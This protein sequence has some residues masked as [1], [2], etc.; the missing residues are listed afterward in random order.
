MY[1]TMYGLCLSLVVAGVLWPYVGHA[2]GP[3]APAEVFHV[4]PDG[5]DGWSGR[6]AE[7]HPDGADGPWASIAGARDGLRRLRQEG[8]LEGPVLVYVR[9]GEYALTEPVVFGPEDSGTA[10]AHV[11][12]AAYPGETPLLHGGVSITGWEQDGA[13]W[14]ARVPDADAS[15]RPTALWVDGQRRTPARTPNAANEAGDYPTDADFFF[16]AGQLSETDAEGNEVKSRTKFQFRPGDLQAWDSLD[17]AWVVVYHSWATSLLPVKALDLE[18]HVAEFTGPARWPFGQWRSDQW[19]YVEHLREGLDQPGE[20]FYDRDARTMH[21]MPMP[22]EDMAA[23]EAIAPVAE[24]LLLLEG[25]PENGE[26][27]EFLNFRGL[28]F[29]YTNYVLAET[30]ISD[31]QAAFTV[32]AAVQAIGARNCAI[33]HCEIRHV[34]NYAVWWRRG[35]QDNRLFHCEL[36]DMGAGGVRIG[37]GSDPATP[38]EAALR[39]VID[40]N[41]IH[42]GG[43]LFREAVGV[44]IGRSSWNTVSHNEICDFRYSGV[45]VGW[46]W[47]YAESSANHN[48]IEFNHIHA[49]GK[50]QLNDMG[51]IYTLGVSPGTVLRYN[52][53]HDVLSNPKLY[54]GWGLYTDEG[55]SHIL[56]ENNVVYNTH[57]GG[58]HQHYG[59]DNLVRNNILAYSHTGQVIRSREED[60]N[61]FNFERNI[62][63]FNNGQLLGS[64]WRNN[65]FEFDYNCYWD[66]SGAPLEFSGRTWEEWRALGH[67]THS[68]IADPMFI[69][70]E[71]G[72]LRLQPD[73]PAIAL[74]FKPIDTSRIGLY[75]TEEWVSKPKQIERPPFS[76]PAPPEPLRVS[77]DFEG[78][79]VG[80]QMPGANVIGETAEARIRVS[81]DTA[82]SGRHSLKFIDAAGIEPVWNPHMFLSPHLRSGT[83]RARFALRLEHGGPFYHEWRDN[84]SPYRVGPSLWFHADGRIAAGGREI[85][86]IPLEQWV[87]LEMLCP[88]GQEARGDYELRIDA[89]GNPRQTLTLPLGSP[90]FDRLDWFGFVANGDS[91]AVMYLD[92]L[93]L[94]AE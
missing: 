61:S 93:H 27:V 56:L 15:W 84:R 81:G 33:E 66:T 2:G 22:G 9:G 4:A 48:L 43:R 28:R 52:L 87:R 64:T 32:E 14:S 79:P 92:D 6:P 17:D 68:I 82:A 94:A 76:P 8:K 90:E 30:G 19:Y 42:D 80:A 20:W 41:F 23:V 5:N 38:G 59:K 24:Q 31:A 55:S 83:A 53:I 44:W 46:S 78:L 86:R 58:F 69:A 21:Y 36:F 70:P 60:H 74:G 13:V 51:G 57:T 29:Q 35:C 45:S 18:N 65:N 75:G 47:G 91:A 77:E 3:A 54:G 67:D 62:V 16:A 11:T 7:P 39:N 50:R 1:G 34:N 72:D 37:E 49:I 89:P 10:E 25:K 73:S 26:F 63:L 12:F 40:N 71:M 88:L 85:A